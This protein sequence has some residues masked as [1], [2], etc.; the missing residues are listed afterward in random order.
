[1]P[2][3]ALSWLAA[4][5]AHGAAREALPFCALDKLGVASVWLAPDAVDS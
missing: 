2:L 1:V 4:L 5:G 3:L